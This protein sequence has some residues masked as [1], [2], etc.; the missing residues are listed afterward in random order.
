MTILDTCNQDLDSIDD[1]DILRR[2]LLETDDFSEKKLIR[3]RISKLKEKRLKEF[4]AND[5][6]IGIDSNFSAGTKIKVE[7]VTSASTLRTTDSRKR[8]SQEHLEDIQVDEKMRK[9]EEIIAERIR[10]RSQERGKRLQQIKNEMEKAESLASTKVFNQ[11][12]RIDDVKEGGLSVCNN[13]NEDTEISNEKILDAYSAGI[14]DELLVPAKERV[15]ESREAFKCSPDSSLDRDSIE[16]PI[17][18]SK[19]GPYSATPRVKRS[20]EEIEASVL[21]QME[22]IETVPEPETIEPLMP[23]EQKDTKQDRKSPAKEISPRAKLPEK[24][25]RSSREEKNDDLATDLLL[26]LPSRPVIEDVS[27]LATPSLKEHQ[28]SAEYIVTTP[29]P[30]KQ[31]RRQSEI[32]IEDVTGSSMDEADLGESTLGAVVEPLSKLPSIKEK[33]KKRSPSPKKKTNI[34]SATFDRAGS[35]ARRCCGRERT[36]EVQVLTPAEK[37]E[38]LIA[39]KISVTDEEFERMEREILEQEEREKQK[40]ISPRKIKNI[41]TSGAEP[42]RVRKISPIDNNKS[43]VPSLSSSKPTRRTD[44]KENAL[45]AAQTRLEKP[46]AQ[47][48]ILEFKSRVEEKTS[49]TLKSPTK[50]KVIS[51]TTRPKSG[52][53]SPKT[54]KELALKPKTTAPDGTKA[55]TLMSV[56]KTSGSVESKSKQLYNTQR[57]SGEILSP[58]RSRESTPKADDPNRKSKSKDNSRRSSRD[59]SMKKEVK[60]QDGSKTQGERKNFDA[61]DD[62]DLLER[63]LESAKEYDERSRIRARI[64]A[65][66]R[67]MSSIPI[68]N[69]SSPRAS[70]IL[71]RRLMPQVEKKTPT[72]TRKVDYL[73]KQTSKLKEEPKP[74]DPIITDDQLHGE[75]GQLIT[76]SS[77]ESQTASEVE[78]TL[79]RIKEQQGDFEDKEQNQTTDANKKVIYDHPYEHIP[80]SFVAA[81]RPVSPVIQSRRI[82]D[83]QSSESQVLYR[84]PSFR[85]SPS[86][87]IA[88]ST[89]VYRPQ[90]ATR[91]QPEP[92]EE[93]SRTASPVARR[94]SAIKLEMKSESTTIINE[95][96]NGCEAVNNIVTEPQTVESEPPSE[97]GGISVK[98]ASEKINKVARSST[99]Q[100]NFGQSRLPENDPSQP[101]GSDETRV[102]TSSYGVGPTDDSGRPL[103]GLG[104][105]RKARNRT[106]EAET[107]PSKSFQSQQAR[108]EPTPS[109]GHGRPLFGLGAV[110]APRISRD[111]TNQQLTSVV[112]LE[113]GNNQEQGGS[114]LQNPIGEPSK[115]EVEFK[116]D[117][118]RPGGPSLL[119]ERSRPLSEVILQHEQAILDEMKV[120]E[121]PNSKLEIE[122]SLP[123]SDAIKRHEKAII[124]D[125]H[126]STSKTTIELEKSAPVQEVVNRHK[127]AIEMDSKIFVPKRN[128]EVDKIQSIREI[129]DIHKQKQE[130]EI[131]VDPRAEILSSPRP[132]RKLRDTFLNEP[133]SQPGNTASPPPIRRPGILKKPKEVPV[134]QSEPEKELSS[135]PDPYATLERIEIVKSSTPEKRVSI[136]N[137][138]VVN[139][140]QPIEDAAP[141]RRRSSS[142]SPNR[143][144]LPDEQVV[145]YKGTSSWHSKST[146]SISVPQ[147][148]KTTVTVLEKFPEHDNIEESSWRRPSQQEK[149]AEPSWRK[150]LSSGLVTQQ[151]IYKSEISDTGSKMHTAETEAQPWRIKDSDDSHTRRKNFVPDEDTVAADISWRKATTPA[152]NEAQPMWRSNR[153]DIKRS[154]WRVDDEITLS[155]EINLDKGIPQPNEKIDHPQSWRTHKNQE[156]RDKVETGSS[157]RKVSNEAKPIPAKIVTSLQTI[158]IADVSP[159]SASNIVVRSSRKSREE[160]ITVSSYNSVFEDSVQKIEDADV[161]AHRESSPT[162]SLTPAELRQASIA[163][164]DRR[165][166]VN[167]RW[168]P[169]DRSSRQTTP[170]LPDN[171]PSKLSGRIGGLSSV[172]GLAQKFMQNNGDNGTNKSTKTYPKAGLI[173]RS[174]S[175]K[176]NQGLS[177]SSDEGN[178]LR[179]AGSLRTENSPSWRR[180]V[181]E[182]TDPNYDDSPPWRQKRSTESLNREEKPPAMKDFD[183]SAPKSFLEDRSKVT[184]VSD[185]LDRMRAGNTV[186]DGNGPQTDEQAR[187]LLNK[188]LGA[189]I[190][191]QGVEPILQ[192]NGNSQNLSMA[193]THVVDGVDINACDDHFKLSEMLDN[194]N[195]YEGR[196]KLRARIR[197]LLTAE[198]QGIELNTTPVVNITQ[199]S[200]FVSTNQELATPDEKDLVK[201][202][203]ADNFPKEAKLTDNGTVTGFQKSV[204]ASHSTNATM[205][206]QNEVTSKR[207]IMT[208]SSYRNQ[209]QSVTVNPGGSAFSKFQ[210]LDRANSLSS[211]KT[212][213]RPSVQE[214]K[215]TLLEYCQ[216]CTSGYKN[217]QI[218]DFST[219]WTDGLAFCALIHHFY[220]D[221]FDFDSLEPK[222]RRYNLDLAFK[223]A[224]ERAGIAPLLDVDDMVTMRK[225]DWKCVFTYIQTIYR[226][227]KDE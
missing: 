211:P 68:V 145:T 45:K 188:F 210:Q 225:P 164:P 75:I 67:P 132:R 113:I 93:R 15:L 209:S 121:T 148:E 161:N 165:N 195:D 25:A 102:I 214:I 176:Q 125:R 193:G 104:A 213:N 97:A 167:E 199:H 117:L 55:E 112:T 196:Q 91:S 107:T 140:H 40:K 47:G 22:V 98:A 92:T 157:F 136:D 42:K 181:K 13:N 114:E 150:S 180:S 96:E 124:E 48:K 212:F 129:I 119:T 9:C 115:R 32:E 52:T 86:P 73:K 218:T 66:K 190:I 31:E 186:S 144:L 185:I 72:P 142:S 71:G 26:N 95:P 105:L 24:T 187:S 39:R 126:I 56:S 62:L 101:Q 205:I 182:N 215:A 41:E 146:E 170:D 173:F 27:A 227:L 99:A 14:K 8:N 155:S 111:E 59:E 58:G 159:T 109:D 28:Q 166:S 151:S 46:K 116:V 5:D 12:S 50:S 198:K 30:P 6:V 183:S 203:L 63:L 37:R 206:Q 191:L 219:S 74:G 69:T 35:P 18:S 207:S 61:I 88:A 224:D 217:V 153:N 16:P 49:L 20:A 64:R 85:R 65:L 84:A 169:K 168:Q 54:S 200:A 106:P 223:T 179:R 156:A 204:T 118:C 202:W 94:K 17:R 154:S 38:I 70:P 127:T 10:K 138:V 76:M 160:T 7:T 3:A 177:P 216:R 89:V 130:E 77:L 178:P 131:Q 29:E 90:T 79:S 175:F 221:A 201:S 21:R 226:R 222:N 171:G 163:K 33:T 220:P 44:S 162:R 100:L 197:D 143:A 133:S 152:T 110:K 23:K 122:K 78:T 80:E 123:I 82:E 194:C 60:R 2:K 192:A 158:S 53:Y 189:Q 108:R 137:T 87:V 149:Q 120:V 4:Y 139:G 36:P 83:I 51:S 57:H 128:V 147:V 134:V 81:A 1:E 34:P 43:K 19:Y 11:A 184:G 141:W 174:S 208:S 135:Q 172:K 103:F